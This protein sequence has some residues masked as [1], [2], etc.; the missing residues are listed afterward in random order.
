M[1]ESAGGFSLCFHLTMPSSKGLFQRAIMQS[2]M[3]DIV[4]DEAEVAFEQGEKLKRA[5]KCD[6]GS[7]PAN[8]SALDC[9]RR[10]PPLTVGQALD[11]RRGLLFH[12]VCMH[13]AVRS[14]A[15][16]KEQQAPWSYLLLHTLNSNFTGSPMVSCS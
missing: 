5:V 1:G 10:L 15:T 12:K 9:L 6:Q 8:E 2:A 4:F 14:M 13:N 3:C 16:C 11:N 7:R